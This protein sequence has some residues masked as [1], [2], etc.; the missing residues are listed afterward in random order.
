M[1]VSVLYKVDAGAK[2]DLDYYLATHIPLVRSLWGPQ[3]LSS[4]RV[5]KG[6]GIAGGGAA[7]FSYIALL[8]FEL[9]A[10]FEAAAQKHGAEIIGDIANFT[11]AGPIIQFNEQIG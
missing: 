3:G 4:V 1:I 7:H 8:D 9:M 6:T 2:F 11:D 5:L 10:A